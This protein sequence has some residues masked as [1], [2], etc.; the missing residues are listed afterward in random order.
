MS[1]IDR[2]ASLAIKMMLTPSQAVALPA[3]VQYTA[4]TMGRSEDWAIGE[5]MANGPA[6]EYVAGV[7]RKVTN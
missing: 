7:C 3:A 2:L 1:R 5:L 6:R 4:E